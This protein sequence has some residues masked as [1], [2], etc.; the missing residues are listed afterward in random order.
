MRRFLPLLAVVTLSIF[1][2]PVTAVSQ[3]ELAA[4]QSLSPAQQQALLQQVGGG[5]Q[6]GLVRPLEQPRVVE[7]VVELE[8]TRAA[9]NSDELGHYGYDLFRGNPTTFAP[10]TDVPVPADYVVGPGDV[11][12]VQE[13]GKDSNNYELQINRNGVVALPGVGEVNAVGMSFSE[14]KRTIRNKIERQKI[15]ITASITMGQLRSIRVFVLGD[16]RRPGSYTVS[17]LTTMTNALF[18]S[19]GIKEIGSLRNIQLKRGGQ[20]VSTMDLYD[21]LMR[22]DTSADVR[23]QPGDVLFVPPRGETVSVDG[24]VLRP[25]IYELRN[26]RT[27]AQALKLA[28]GL[29]SNAWREKATIERV[30]PS[31]ERSLLAVSLRATPTETLIRDGD[32]LTVQSTLD[33]VDGAI[34]VHGYAERLGRFAAKNGM[35]LTD[36]VPNAD[37]LKVGA[38][39]DFALL[40]RRDKDTGEISVQ[41]LHPGLAFLNPQG[42]QDAVLRAGDELYFFPSSETADLVLEKEQEKEEKTESIAARKAP[43]EAENEFELT[44]E[45]ALT[46]EQEAVEAKQQIERE[47]AAL[48][49]QQTDD[50]SE[51]DESSRSAVIE[52]LVGELIAQANTVKLANVAKITGAVRFPGRYPLDMRGTRVTDLLRAGGGLEEY[53][54][55]LEA[56]ITRYAVVE[57]AG[58]Q[59]QEAVHIAVNLK[60]AFNGD[61]KANIMLYPR[62]VITV[63]YVPAW[64]Q[65]YEVKI[66]G[67]VQFPGTYPVKRNETIADLIQRAGGL[68]PNAYPRGAALIREQLIVKEQ[69]QA[70]RLSRRLESDLAALSLESLATDGD[71]TQAFL[72]AKG[73]LE[74]LKQYK[75]TGRLVIDLP[76][77][78]SGGLKPITLEGNDE[79]IIPPEPTEV[80]V[81]GEVQFPTSHLFDGDLSRK[82]YLRNSGGITE[83]ADKRRIFVVKANGSVVSGRVKMEPGDTIVVPLDSDRVRP[84]TLWTNITQIIYQLGLAAAGFKAVG[85]F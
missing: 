59:H 53:A 4:F 80:T 40:K 58:K 48:G 14:L 10:A 67:E 12:S 84:L 79:L 22:G 25:A 56:E 81:V 46:G 32:K 69:A 41:Y 29:T 74:E 17:A 3:A 5:A 71:K 83:R 50:A 45:Y 1:S 61:P 51:Q 43:R 60:D 68:T 36:L 76:K 65:Q 38:D 54:Y 39:L 27:V 15:G 16:A 42:A 63:R 30:E 73:L 9:A 49:L 7:P 18:V 8:Q 35:R 72:A 11:I 23:L 78:L 19:G 37:A 31:G 20:I 47:K 28:G 82:D 62:D 52:K 85:A 33:N 57:K 34:A 24:E 55:L 26:E 66:S 2:L 6:N 77:M 64:D 21:L 44:N 75:P 13:Y 70:E